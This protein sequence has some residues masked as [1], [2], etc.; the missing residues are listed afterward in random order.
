MRN[1]MLAVAVLVGF[2]GPAAAQDGKM[3]PAELKARAAKAAA[4]EAYENCHTEWLT[5]KTLWAAARDGTDN[6]RKRY[7]NNMMAWTDPADSAL[8][9]ALITNAEAL[10][11]DATGWF[12]SGEAASVAGVVCEVAGD[13][14]LA[15][16]DWD[17][18]YTAYTDAAVFYD[19]ALGYYLACG[20]T[21]FS[22]A[23]AAGAAWVIMNIYQPWW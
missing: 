7:K 19:L 15:A 6:T 4:V 23:Q 16:G 20:D 2:A 5:V 11:K 3:N 9:G 8:I 22:E 18:A 17:G 1:A 10:G 21:A 12:D 14:K 13:A